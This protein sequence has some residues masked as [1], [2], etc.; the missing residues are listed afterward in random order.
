[1]CCQARVGWMAVSCAWVDCATRP[2]GLAVT[3]TQRRACEE[4]LPGLCHSKY[5]NA[6]L[7]TL[8]VLYIYDSVDDL[9]LLAR[10]TDR[11]FFKWKSC[12]N[13]MVIVWSSLPSAM[14]S[15]MLYTLLLSL[16]DRS[17]TI[18]NSINYSRYRGR[19]FWLMRIG[20]LLLSEWTL[21]LLILLESVTVPV[22]C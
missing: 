14:T 2:A 20:T 3:M 4:S 13:D 17:E 15:C 7:V 1:M 5:L 12:T 10:G 8:R 18:S 16:R 9:Y 6:K 19:K 11:L 22:A 21:F